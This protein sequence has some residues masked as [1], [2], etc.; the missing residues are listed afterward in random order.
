MKIEF[1]NGSII[2]SLKSENVIRGKGF[3]Y[4]IIPVNP[5]DNDCWLDPYTGRGYKYLDGEW[6]E[7]KSN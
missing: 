6:I 3:Y 1:N 7:N 4:E 2:E 5:K